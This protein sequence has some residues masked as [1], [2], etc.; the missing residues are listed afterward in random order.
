MIRLFLATL[1]ACW[2]GL[3][4]KPVVAD[5]KPNEDP[6]AVARRF[7]PPNSQLEQ[8]YSLDYRAGHVAK[9]WPAVLTAHIVSPDSRDIVFAYR[10]PRSNDA[11]RFGHNL[12]VAFLHDTDEGYEEIY[13]ASYQN[14]VLLAP[15]AIRI[16][17]L[18]GMDTDAVAVIHGIG[19]AL[20]GRLDIYTWNKTWGLRNVFPLNGGMDYVYYFPR[21]EGFTIA[22]ASWQAKRPGLDVQPPPI[23]YQWNGKRFINIPPPKGSSKWPIRGY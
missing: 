21:L 7:L 10:T 11:R 19:A 14:E 18:N 1:L 4:Q 20:G 3:A 22:L 6:V 13:V 12:F 2:V 8:L 17:H 15:E 23:W 5:K 16:L 9:R